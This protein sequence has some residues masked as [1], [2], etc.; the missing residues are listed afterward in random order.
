VPSDCRSYCFNPDFSKQDNG[1][2]KKKREKKIE[3]SRKQGFL[4]SFLKNRVAGD[5]KKYDFIGLICFWGKN[6]GKN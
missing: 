4:R 5:S 2:Q 3:K 1:K 6:G